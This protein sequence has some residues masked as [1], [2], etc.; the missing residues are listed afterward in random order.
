M[1]RRPSGLAEAQAAQEP[2]QVVVAVAYARRVRIAQEVVASVDVER[3]AHGARQVGELV[4]ACHEIG[5]APRE[6]GIIRGEHAVDLA[7]GVEQDARG[8]RFVMCGAGHRR[9]EEVRERAVT[10]VV[11]EGGRDRVACTLAGHALPEGQIAID[12]S[13]PREEEL[14]HVRGPD[15]M[16]EPGVLRAW[17][18]E[19]GQPELADPAQPLHLSRAEEARYDRVFFAFERDEPMNRV[20]QDQ[21]RPSTQPS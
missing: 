8:P 20:T 14:H 1:T 16:R 21:A 11:Q 17:I 6:A 10:D 13:E 12:L 3:A 18:G 19:R 15:R 4:L 7:R 9:F 5:D 2:R